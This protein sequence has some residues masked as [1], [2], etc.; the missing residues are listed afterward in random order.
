MM[1]LCS[2][3]AAPSVDAQ[4]Y[5]TKPIRFI[6]PTSAGGTIDVAARM[7]AKPLEAVLGQPVLVENRPGATYMLATDL[8]AH[9][10]ADGHTICQINISTHSFNPYI[11]K[12]IPYDPI[13]D[14]KPVYFQLNAVQAFTASKSLPANTV[15]EVK[16][17]A[18]KNKGKL[19]FA[20][21]GPGSSADLFRIWLN[22]E[23][24][25]DITGVAYGGGIAVALMSGESQLSIVAVGTMAETVRQGNA[26]FLAFAAKE[27][28]TQFP[29]VATFHETGLGAYPSSFWLGIAVPARTPDDVVKRLNAAFN[30]AAKD[31]KYREYLEANALQLGPSTPEE[32]AEFMAR[33]RK[34]AETIIKLTGVQ[35]K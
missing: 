25:S 11:F 27:R 18:L 31:P 6:V 32:F 1:L 20:T 24:G 22:K 16:D 13:K 26:K 34:A 19:N 10:P 9:A 8:C 7:I 3:F 4:Q 30:E 2:L 35:P 23:W 33:D 17:Y 29:G 28:I 5:P 12:K 15:A 21:L 14:F